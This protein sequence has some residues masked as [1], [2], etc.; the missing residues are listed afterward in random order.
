MDRIYSHQC[1]IEKIFCQYIEIG[2]YLDSVVERLEVAVTIRVNSRDA[3]ELVQFCPN[4]ILAPTLRP[5]VY[6]LKI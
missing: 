4:I 5:I 6:S 3:L 1:L 2:V